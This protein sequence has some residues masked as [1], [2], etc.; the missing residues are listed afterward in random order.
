MV[1]I[2]GS[3]WRISRASRSERSCFIGASDR[4][5]S[6]FQ[7]ERDMDAN[8]RGAVPSSYLWFVVCPRI[9]QQHTR[10]REVFVVPGHDVQAVASRRSSNETVTCGNDLTR[11]LRGGCEFSPGVAGLE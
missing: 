9:E 1:V 11:S 7:G 2:S 6:V 4:P 5:L 10:R 3:P 8:H